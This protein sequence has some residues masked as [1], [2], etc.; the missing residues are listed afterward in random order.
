MASVEVRAI[1]GMLA[2][3]VTYLAACKGC[4]RD[5]DWPVT[6]KREAERELRYDGWEVIG[7]HWLCSDCRAAWL[8]ACGAGEAKGAGDGSND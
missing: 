5:A 7:G 4:G 1:P 8:R 6:T 3:H 2:R